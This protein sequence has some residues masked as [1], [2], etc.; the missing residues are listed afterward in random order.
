MLCKGLTLKWSSCF[1]IRLLL[2]SSPVSIYNA[3]EKKVTISTSLL[4]VYALYSLIDEY[5]I[6]Q[7]IFIEILIQTQNKVKK[8]YKN[9]R[10]FDNFYEH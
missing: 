1:W 10:F 9:F 4:L 5:N 8:K 3:K 2:F 6:L 7:G